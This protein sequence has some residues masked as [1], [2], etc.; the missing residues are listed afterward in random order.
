MSEIKLVDQEKFL[1]S[2]MHVSEHIRYVMIYDLKGNIL[3]KRKMDGV[4]DLL[5][6]NENKIA[7]KHTIESWKFRNNIS[8]K[9]GNAN[10]TLQVYDNLMRVL[11]PFG[12]KALL[13]VTLDKAGSP[14]DIIERIQT[15]LS[16]NPSGLKEYFEGQSIPNDEII[17][18]LKKSFDYWSGVDEDSRIECGLVWKKILKDNSEFLKNQTILINNNTQN[19]AVQVEQFL[20]SWSHAIEEPD[21]YAAKKLIQNWKDVLENTSKENMELYIKVLELLETSWENLQSK[22]IE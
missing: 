9:I 7:L 18:A 15:I 19:T 3:F 12:D 20:E 17:N 5:T 1:N 16:G 4:T 8:E 11:F 10:Y 22:N 13:I 21:F 6:E 2:I 14:N